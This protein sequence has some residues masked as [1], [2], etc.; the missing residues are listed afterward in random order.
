[1]KIAE[2][3]AL[4][5]A[6]GLLAPEDSE[7]ITGSLATQG[8]TSAMPWYLQALVALGAWLAALAL[9]GFVFGIFFRIIEHGTGGV[10][11]GLIL[12]TA[13]TALERARRG[14][15]LSQAALAFSASG[16][17]IVLV[18][19][20]QAAHAFG[21][22]VVCAI[23]LAAV[24]YR[25]YP[26]PLHRFLATGTAL[27]LATAWLIF[28]DALHDRPFWTCAS[29]VAHIV[30]LGLLFIPARG[31]RIWRPLAFAVAVSLLGLLL[32]IVVPFAP[33]ALHGFRLPLGIVVAT[34]LL[35]V[36]GWAAGGARSLEAHR[37][38]AV[39]VSLAVFALALGSNPA[40]VAAVGVLVLGFSLQDRPLVWIGGL[41]LPVFVTL[42][43]YNLQMS[44]RDKSL[45]LLATGAVLV[46]LELVL[47]RLFR[48]KPA[49]SLP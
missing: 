24:F 29:V 14:P 13:A 23:V 18:S 33:L 41:S 10:I 6:N 4:A 34:A 20:T 2:L 45:L 19:A 44:L 38:A 43:Y 32:L 27:A 17:L 28:S 31:R 48:P 3:L 35:G 11:T 8:K 30:L 49:T 1:M 9:L 7:R 15:F 36:L 16:H 25:L 46:I 21:A 42:F 22:C 5:E 40:I 12:I 39:F 47:A 37:P 26:S